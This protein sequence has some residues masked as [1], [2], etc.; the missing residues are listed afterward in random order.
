MCITSLEVTSWN[1]KVVAQCYFHTVRVIKSWI[2][3]QWGGGLLSLDWVFKSKLNGFLQRHRDVQ[4]LHFCPVFIS[5]FRKSSKGRW[6]FQPAFNSLNLRLAK[7]IVWLQLR[8]IKRLA[9]YFGLSMATS[10]LKCNNITAVSL[11]NP[12]LL[13]WSRLAKSHLWRG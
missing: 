11:P 6:R 3:S 9:L 4:R 10:T 1:W 5:A 8:E 2:N 12:T 13:K 7:D